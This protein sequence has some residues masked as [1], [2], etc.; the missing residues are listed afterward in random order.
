M[1]AYQ[2]AVAIVVAFSSPALAVTGARAE[3]GSNAAYWVAEQ[4]R[5]PHTVKPAERVL[6]AV[7]DSIWS[8]VVRSAEAHGV[9]P[10]IAV[11][12]VKVESGGRCS[13]HNGHALGLMQLMPG[14]ART[15][16]VRDR[17][18]CIQNLDGGIRMLASIG[19]RHGWS[20]SALSLYE[21]GEAARPRCTPYARLVLRTMARI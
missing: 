13:A 8:L 16:G 18:D 21:R 20:C 17:M 2:F 10:D 9:P 7:G 14:T 6:K 4:Q 5:R 11:A 19:R 12:V 15:L 1:K 3:D